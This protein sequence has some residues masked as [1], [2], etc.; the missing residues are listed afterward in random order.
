MANHQSNYDIPVLLGY[1]PG[2][3][4]W[5]AKAELFKIPI[6]GRS[7]RGCGYIS[8]DRFNRQS[9]I[10]S[11]NKAADRIKNGASVVIFPE[12]TRS[13]DGG[14]MAFK[15]GGFVLAIDAGVPIIPVVIDGTRG[16]MPK[17]RMLIKPNRVLL[18]VLPAVETMA[19]TREN[20]EELMNVIR[21]KM[22]DA[23]SAI[24]GEHA[25]R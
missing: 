3:F 23:F 5:L 10:E 14:I 19:Y 1:L 11:L 20:K 7:M 18:K 4:R 21:K 16:I 17:K 2:Q 8:I 6:F 12:G 25:C 15:K 24:Q 13:P 22:C 9:A